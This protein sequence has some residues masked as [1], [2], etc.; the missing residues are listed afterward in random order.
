M[1]LFYAV[2]VSNNNGKKWLLRNDACMNL[3]IGI[4]SCL[5]DLD[6]ELKFIIKVPFL[7]EVDDVDLYNRLFESKYRHNISFYEE[8]IPISPVDSRFSFNFTFHKENK[9]WFRNMDVMINDENTLTKNWNALFSSL[10]LDIPIISTNYFLDSP[11]ANKVPEKIRYY[12]RQMESF[13]NS[14]IS[15]FQ[16]EASKREALES[17]NLLYKESGL[18]KRTSVWGVGAWAKEIRKYNNE[19][20]FSVPMIYFGNRITDTANRYTNWDDFAKAIGIVSIKT[21]I[22]SFDAVMLNPTKKITKEQEALIKE[23]SNG[24]VTVVP[25]DHL[26]PREDYLKFINRAHI[27]C[28]LFTTEVHGGITH[29]EALLS[30]NIV[31][32][33]RINNYLDKFENIDYPF[34]CRYDPYT[35]KINVDDLADKILLALS[36]IDTEEELKY[37]KLCQE[38]GYEKESYEMAAERILFD[39]RSL[40]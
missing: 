20:K 8:D 4:I 27:S 26:F 21:D 11:I 1:K 19:K 12:E 30:N 5:L 33:P 16:C 31:V 25:N 13:I 37:N 23:Y 38:I 36:T 15:A 22:T 35:M 9:S 6:P 17:F 24:K 28:N 40:L 18:I 39:V 2:Q 10:G 34:L 3:C 14:D 32:M 29:V 7:K